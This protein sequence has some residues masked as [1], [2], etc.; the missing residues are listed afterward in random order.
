MT[1]LVSFEQKLQKV[2]ALLEDRIEYELVAH[3]LKE[4]VVVLTE[5]TGKSVSENAMDLI[6]KEFCVGKYNISNLFKLEI[7]VLLIF[8]IFL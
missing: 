4:A 2:K 3:H 7:E 6:F 1:L 8:Y 5:L